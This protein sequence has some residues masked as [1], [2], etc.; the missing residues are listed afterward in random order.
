MVP[1]NRLFESAPPALA[2]CSREA[3]VVRA[4]L[5]ASSLSNALFVS[6]CF[7]FL[8]RRFSAKSSISFRCLASNAA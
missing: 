2:G 6:A 7:F 3:Q 5:S 8:A 4:E 1:F